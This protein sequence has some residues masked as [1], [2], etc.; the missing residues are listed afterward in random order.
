MPSNFLHFVSVHI[1]FGIQCLIKAIMNDG[2]N[3][4]FFIVN[5][6]RN[7][8]YALVDVEQEL[9]IKSEEKWNVI[10]YLCCFLLLLHILQSKMFVVFPRNSKIERRNRVKGGKMKN[11]LYCLINSSRKKENQIYFRSITES[12]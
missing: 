9:R 1:I 12:D 3:I 8:Q 10:V 7:R 6:L 2:Q 11:H 4:F 5:E